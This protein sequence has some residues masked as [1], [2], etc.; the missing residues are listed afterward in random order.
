[1]DLWLERRITGV[2]KRPG[3]IIKKLYETVNH[4][5]FGL[6]CH[7]GAWEGTEE[8]NREIDRMAA[9]WVSHAHIDWRI[10]TGGLLEEKLA[11]LWNIGYKGY[12]S[13]EHHTGRDEYSEVAIQLA[14]VRKTLERL[15]QG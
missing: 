11:N 5:A 2:P 6:S 4:P 8:E 12:Y 1:M 9:P 15:Q 3:T 7:L 14:H 10:C 13:V